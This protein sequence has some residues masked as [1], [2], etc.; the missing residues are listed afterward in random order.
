MKRIVMLG[1]VSL[2]L[3]GCYTTRG[4]N[5][6]APVT[7]AAPTTTSAVRAASNPL[8]PEPLG[9]IRTFTHPG[10]EADVTV[11][12]V[13]QNIA[14]DAPTPPTGG[15]WAGADIQT[16]LKQTDTEFTVSGSDW[17]VADAQNGQYN[18]TSETY[19]DFPT[20]QYPFS[21]EPVAV[22]TCVRG[23]VLFPVSYGIGIITVKYKPSSKTPAIWSAT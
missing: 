19:S 22:G 5:I 15:H 10:F 1:T 14:P 12:S 2:I 9:T 6:A 23:W 8:S 13:N 3:A 17:S 7:T 18:A 21:S 20:P 4:I 16:C 11:F